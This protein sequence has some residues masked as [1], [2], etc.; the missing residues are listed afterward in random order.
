MRN[1]AGHGSVSLS[2]CGVIRKCV[3]LYTS[4]WASMSFSQN[5]YRTTHQLNSLIKHIQASPKHLVSSWYIFLYFFIFVYLRAGASS[6][7]VA[8]SYSHIRLDWSFNLPS[9]TVITQKAY[10]NIQE[11]E[12]VIGLSGRPCKPLKSNYQLHVPT[13]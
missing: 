10:H 6:A 7:W 3:V 9:F 11:N 2:H 4:T 5:H 1:L 8:Y 12:L 13:N